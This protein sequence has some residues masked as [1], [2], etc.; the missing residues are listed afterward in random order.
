MPESV[1]PRNLSEELAYNI[2]AL[3]VLLGQTNEAVLRLALMAHDATQAIE[4]LKDAVDSF[5]AD[6]DDGGGHACALE[7][8]KREGEGEGGPGGP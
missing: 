7:V 4:R 2:S 3:V 6:E 8:V 1:D 5:A